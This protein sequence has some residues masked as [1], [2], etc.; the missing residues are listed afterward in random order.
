VSIVVSVTRVE[1]TVQ[2]VIEVEVNQGG[3]QMFSSLGHNICIVYHRDLELDLMF[4]SQQGL[5][6]GPNVTH[7]FHRLLR[8]AGLP[9]MRFTICVTPARRCSWSRASIHVSVMETL[10]HS[11]DQL[12]D[13]HRQSRLPALQREAADRWR[14]Y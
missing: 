11:Q 2:L 3:L 6:D 4:A 5:A 1:N 13:E 10:G 12:D 9:L 8:K 14:Q 7:R